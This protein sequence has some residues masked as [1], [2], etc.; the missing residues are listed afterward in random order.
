MN[1]G[2]ATA[3]TLVV[4]ETAI[5]FALYGLVRAAT[6]PARPRADRATPDLG[7]EPPAVVNL[8][9]NRWKPTGDAEQAILL[10]LAASG[11]IELVQP[12]DD[13]AD[14]TVVALQSNA[15]SLAPYERRVLDRVATVASGRPVPLTALSFRDDGEAKRWRSRL[16][17]EIVADARK[18]GLSRRR[19]GPFATTFLA[20]A[21]ILVGIATAAAADATSQELPVGL[22]TVGLALAVT[23]LR[24][25]GERDTKAGRA[26]ASHWL[27]VRASFRENPAMEY[28]PPAAAAHWGSR[29]AYGAA[30]G[31][32]R[33]AG[34]VLDLGMS[35]RRLV[36]SQHGGTWHRVRVAY[37]RWGKRLGRSAGDLT[38]SALKKLGVG[39]L[40]VVFREQ[41]REWFSGLLDGDVFDIVEP[42]ALALGCV[43]LAIGA[44]TLV[45][46][47]IDLPA[48]RTITGEVLWLEPFPGGEVAA[49]YLAIDDGTSDRTTAWL[50][51]DELTCHVGDTVRVTV[52]AWTRRVGTL[53]VLQ[54]SRRPV[55]PDGD[56]DVDWVMAAHAGDGVAAGSMRASKWINTVNAVI[57]GS[58]PDA[59]PV[60]VTELLASGEV[61]RALHRTVRGPFAL[62]GSGR[63]GFVDDQG[64]AVLLIAAAKTGFIQRMNWVGL[65]RA[66]TPVPGLESAYVLGNMAVARARRYIV[67][68]VLTDTSVHAPTALAT[69]L[70]AVVTRLLRTAKGAKKRT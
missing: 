52:S 55:E 56:V 36:W 3:V 40:L 18:R 44:Y 61:G 37:P 48:K 27:G 64:R 49:E 70:T 11:H 54:R 2:F 28:L 45:R 20:S 21:G 53:T 59:T 66:G 69:L 46:L 12:G 63:I 42:A 43:L 34:S 60:T 14:T 29:L 67:T 26:A 31:V 4:V 51:P 32:A 19:F 6:A 41:P 24:Y 65:A 68:L 10:G 38:K 33:R 22:I 5:W 15:N 25:P 57:N 8:L 9:V 35:S 23:G 17:A 62:R 13:P 30:L 39:V 58:L 7:D 50:L 47:V 16:R 1:P